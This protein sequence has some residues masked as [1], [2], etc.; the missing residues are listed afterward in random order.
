VT[1]ERTNQDV[2][3]LLMG[4]GRRTVAPGQSGHELLTGT[5]RGRSVTADR[6]GEWT[7]GPGQRGASVVVLVPVFGE[8]FPDLRTATPVL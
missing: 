2:L 7:R 4:T 1:A 8:V 6:T 3:E 5:V